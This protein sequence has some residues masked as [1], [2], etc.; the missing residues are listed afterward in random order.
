M[1]GF[2]FVLFFDAHTDRHILD[3]VKSFEVIKNIQNTG[4]SQ[5]TRKQESTHCW[6]ACDESLHC[7]GRM[8]QK[9]HSLHSHLIVK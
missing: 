6:K 7:C 5:S 3:R 9:T 1:R 4:Q 8:H 2:A